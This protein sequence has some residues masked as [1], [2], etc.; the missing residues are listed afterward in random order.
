MDSKLK[1]VRYSSPENRSGVRVCPT[2]GRI[3][4]IREHDLLCKVEARNDDPLKLAQDRYRQALLNSQLRERST[5]IC[6]DGRA[7]A[8]STGGSCAPHCRH[9]ARQ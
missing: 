5:K 1:L 7:T 3:S 2:G 9:P 4:P 8:S 6:S